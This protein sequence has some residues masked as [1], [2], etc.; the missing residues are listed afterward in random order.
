V[1]VTVTFVLFQPELLGAGDAVA[2]MLTGPLKPACWATGMT[3]PATV[4]VVVR[5][6]SAKFCAMLYEIAADEMPDAELTV[7]HPSAAVA[8]QG[9]EGPA[10]MVIVPFCPPAGASTLLG[11]TA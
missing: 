8:T 2:L 10:T 9:H 11:E 1:N 4:M 6:E 5:G 3:F 7:A